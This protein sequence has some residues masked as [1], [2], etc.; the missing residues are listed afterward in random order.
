[1][2]SRRGFCLMLPAAAGYL[3]QAQM[4]STAGSAMGDGEDGGDGW[5][6]DSP[7]DSARPYVLWMWMGSNVSASGITKDLEAMKAAGIGGATIMSLADSC[8]PWAGF[9][10][11]SPTPDV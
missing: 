5:S 2:I 3:S 1:M 4:P 10:G 11:N 9:I 7:P 8:I 6:F